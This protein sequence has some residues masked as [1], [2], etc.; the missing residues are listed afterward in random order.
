[1]QKDYAMTKQGV[2][3]SRHGTLRKE[4][5]IPGLVHVLCMDVVRLQAQTS[6]SPLLDVLSRTLQTPDQ[7]FVLNLQ[8]SSS[9]GMYRKLA[10][11]RQSA[12]YMQC[13][14]PGWK[15][16]YQRAKRQQSHDWLLSAR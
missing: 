14:C 6:I 15:V 10:L 11:H 2:S 1:M 13:H 3:V 7:A 5:H 8:L 16:N 12:V 9:H 4:A